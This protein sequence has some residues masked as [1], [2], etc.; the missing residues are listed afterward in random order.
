MNMFIFMMLEM[1]IILKFIQVT[2][3]FSF[4]WYDVIDLFLEAGRIMLS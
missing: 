2:M 4:Y 1:Q 3:C